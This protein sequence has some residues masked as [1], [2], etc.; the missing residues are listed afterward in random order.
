M[1]LVVVPLLVTPENLLLSLAQD[2]SP[3]ADY[4]KEFLRLSHLVTWSDDMLKTCF[5]SG[6]DDNL[7]QLLPAGATTSMLAQYMDSLD[8]ATQP[9]PTQPTSVILS[10]PILAPV[11]PPAVEIIPSPSPFLHMPTTNPEPVPKPTTDEMPEPNS[12][13]SRACRDAYAKAEACGYHHPGARAQ[14]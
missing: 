3:L 1:C 9:Q 13:R 6:L 2:G 14:Q 4:L 10:P 12:E 8:I 11:T 7:F 5:W